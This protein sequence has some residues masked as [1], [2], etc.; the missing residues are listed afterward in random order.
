[1]W[2]DKTTTQTMYLIIILITSLRCSKLL[3]VYKNVEKVELVY[4]SQFSCYYCMNL[5]Y[6]LKSMTKYWHIVIIENSRVW[7][8]AV[9]FYDLERS[10]MSGIC[11]Y[12]H[13]ACF[14]CLKDSLP[15]ALLILPFL[16]A[17]GNA[18]LASPLELHFCRRLAFGVVWSEAFLDI[19][20]Q[21]SKRALDSC[22][23]FHD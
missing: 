7:C 9:H 17:P 20:F 10:I 22:V 19:I 14:P 11:H 18:I 1:M 3:N 2:V 12:C 15:H 21:L 8:Y 23:S 13:T 5:E 6:L 16:W 4:I